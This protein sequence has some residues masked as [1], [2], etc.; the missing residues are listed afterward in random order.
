MEQ[1][2]LVIRDGAGMIC[3]GGCVLAVILLAVTLHRIRKNEKQMKKLAEL[4][5]CTLLQVE[6]LTELTRREPAEKE[7]KAEPVPPVKEREQ[8]EELLS[9]VL[10]E[11]F[12]EM[13]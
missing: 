4:A 13:L 8:P 12:P 6:Q 5:E 1:I 3:V 7:V 11:V 10:G 9:A 2:W